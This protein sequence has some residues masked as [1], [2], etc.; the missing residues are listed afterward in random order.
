M[1]NLKAA[2]GEKEA[3][4]IR[5]R[6]SAWAKSCN[7]TCADCG[8]TNPTWASVN[9][10]VLVCLECAG[11]HRSLGTH[12]SKMRSITLDTVLPEEAHFLLQMTN[13]LANRYWEARLPSSERS[14]ALSQPSFVQQKY[15]DRRWVLQDPSIPVPSR[16]CVPQ[17]HPWWSAQDSSSAAEAVPTSVQPAPVPMLKPAMPGAAMF[18][19]QATPVVD[20]SDLIDFGDSPS[21]VEAPTSM[22]PDPF[23]TP[24]A[25]ATV[26]PTANTLAISDPF[27]AAAAPAPAPAPNLTASQPQQAPVDPFAALSLGN[28][29]RH[30][31]CPTIVS[32]SDAMPILCRLVTRPR[33]QFHKRMPWH[34]CHAVTV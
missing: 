28:A 14:Q 23:S 21:P 10:G 12:I 8:R 22:E 19:K 25:P 15:T 6:L 18:Q 1:S 20:A 4:I 26:P 13:E 9:L 33:S 30:H 24:H 29:A 31:V 17:A 2:V 34:R 27:A 3:A 11:R 5:K 7:P 32:C 16:D